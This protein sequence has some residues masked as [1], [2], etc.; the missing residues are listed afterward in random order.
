MSEREK[1][2]GGE[3]RG[4]RALCKRDVMRDREHYFLFWKRWH[5]WRTMSCV[6]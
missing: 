1:E 5:D 3:E 6:M 4:E 2:G